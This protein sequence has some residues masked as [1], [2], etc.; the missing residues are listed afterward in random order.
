MD[1]TYRL[2]AAL[3]KIAEMGPAEEPDQ[4]EFNSY[5][6]A[7]SWGY[8]TGLYEAAVSARIMLEELDQ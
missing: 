1:H 8:Q 5:G 2:R 6:D 7:A 3:R 4:G